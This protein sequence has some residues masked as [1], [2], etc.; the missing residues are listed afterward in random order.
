MLVL[1]V[2]DVEDGMMIIWRRI[3]ASLAQDE[4]WALNPKGE[5]SH[6]LKKKKPAPYTETGHGLKGWMIDY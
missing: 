4:R 1:P 6:G 5:W 3:N 2:L